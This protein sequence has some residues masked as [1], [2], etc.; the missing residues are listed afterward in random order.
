MENGKG[1][2]KKRISACFEGEVTVPKT[3]IWLTGML[4]LTAGI[5][6][7]LLAAPWTRGVEIACNNGNEENYY[8]KED[9]EEEDSE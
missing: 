9:A 7:G 6:Y 2:W 3:T 5:V 4:C 1:K 8:V